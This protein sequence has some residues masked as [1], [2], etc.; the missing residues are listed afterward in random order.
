MVWYSLNTSKNRVQRKKGKQSFSYKNIV[1]YKIR[2]LAKFANILADFDLFL[3]IIQLD[4]LLKDDCTD[5]NVA[6]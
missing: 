3:S 2:N 4:S 1:L 6:E 5:S